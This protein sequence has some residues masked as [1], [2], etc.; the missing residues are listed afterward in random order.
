MTHLM[1]FAE[2]SCIGKPNFRP[3]APFFFC[4][5][6]TIFGSPFFDIERGVVI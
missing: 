5:K 6:S 4:G 1:L 2:S 3:V